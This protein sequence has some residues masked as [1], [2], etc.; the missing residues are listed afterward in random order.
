MK[1][2]IRLTESQLHRVIKE[3]VKRVL[4]E[5]NE[6][7]DE[8]TYSDSYDLGKGR[9]RQE[10]IYRGKEIGFLLSIEKNPYAPIEETYV[11]PDIDYGMQEGGDALLD[12]KKGWID[13]KCFKSYEEA[14]TYAKANF[15]EISYLF[16]YG[17]YD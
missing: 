3:S 4:R 9:H 15:D 2:R 16:Q 7:D 12:E 11:L 10:I 1:Q 14:F 8:F 17:D 13:F 6:L 5:S